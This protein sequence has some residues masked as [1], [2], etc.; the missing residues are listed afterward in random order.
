MSN[1]HP[2]ATVPSSAYWR[3]AVMLHCSVDAPYL[4]QT[5][6]AAWR[7]ART[8]GL[9]ETPVRFAV[10]RSIDQNVEGVVPRAVPRLT[11][12]ADGVGESETGDEEAV[13]EPPISLQPA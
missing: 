5:N 3:F 11:L 7:K 2:P 6:G 13:P 12:A 10:C 8:A 9:E 1:A 4:T